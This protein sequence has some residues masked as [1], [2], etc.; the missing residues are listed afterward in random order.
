ML[1]WMKANVK[2]I[3]QVERFKMIEGMRRS[4]TVLQETSGEKTLW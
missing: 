3:C 4:L 1:A 2:S